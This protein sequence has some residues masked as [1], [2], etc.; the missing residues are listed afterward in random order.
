MNRKSLLMRM[1]AVI[2]GL[3]LSLPLLLA[4]NKTVKGVVLDE[5]EQGVIG[6]AV[7]IKGTNNGVATDIDGN[8]ELVCAPSDV[9]VISSI[10]YKDAEVA[11]GDKSVFT[12]HLDLDQELLDDV[13]V[14]G[15]GTTRAK[16]FTGSVDVMKVGEDAPVA[17]LGLSSV[18]DMMRGRLSGVVMGSESPTVGGNASIR[19]R[20]RDRLHR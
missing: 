5:T 20:W 6:A 9:L 14:I 12:I 17:N 1:V 13:V 4:Q 11:V 15:Y 8:F 7:M 18:S 2:C 16:N 10:G 3:V 19:V